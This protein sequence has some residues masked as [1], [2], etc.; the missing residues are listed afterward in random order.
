VLR[1]QPAISFS[2]A[3]ITFL[4]EGS[5]IRVRS[6]PNSLTA[7]SFSEFVVEL[8]NEGALPIRDFNIE[9]MP[10]WGMEMRLT[11]LSAECSL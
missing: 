2:V 4:V 9:T 5:N 11:W 8:E 3:R 10:A 1:I 6:A 7:G